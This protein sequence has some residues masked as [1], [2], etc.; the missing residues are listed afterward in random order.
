MEAK[1]ATQGAR[2]TT[3]LHGQREHRV[4]DA[5]LL[6][7]HG[8]RERR[9]WEEYPAAAEALPLLLVEGAAAINCK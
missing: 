8:P 2:K 9:A 4:R 6:N 1:K 7:L 3:Q 5:R